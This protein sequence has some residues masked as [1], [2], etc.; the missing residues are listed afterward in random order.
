[1]H[2]PEKRTS[3]F[4]LMD[5]PMPSNL[6]AER[7]VLGSILLDDARMFDVAGALTEQDFSIQKHQRIFATMQQMQTAG[8]SIDQVTVAE[9]LHR[10]GLLESIDGAFYLVSLNDG[11]P[12]L[13]N[14]DSYIRIVREKSILRQTMHACHA[15]MAECAVGDGTTSDLLS[16]GERVLSELQGK[17]AIDTEFLTPGEIIMEAGGMEAYFRSRRIPGLQT[18]WP[19]FNQSTSGLQRGHLTIL[20]ARTG[21]GKSAFAANIAVSVARS[22]FGVALF[23][24]EMDRVEITDRVIALAGGTTHKALRGNDV[25]LVRTSANKAAGLPLFTSD[26][27]GRSVPSIHAAVRRLRAKQGVALVIVD[28]LQLLSPAGKFENRTQ[29]VSAMTRGLKLAAQDLRIP[30]LVLSQLKR[31][32]SGGGNRR[33]ELSD[34]RES[35]SIEQD[36]NEVFFLDWDRGEFAAGVAVPVTMII[37]K[38]RSGPLEDIPM[39]FHRER[40]LFTEAS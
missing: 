26:A 14:I 8:L 16:R 38:Q 10:K 39:Y 15:L 32:E 33:P 6:D 4:S 30:F 1:M 20:A 19:K 21:H 34:L 37:A 40:G 18:D 25:D 24:L 27:A 7:F 29:E 35:G 13:P 31:A 2:K 36:A 11:L 5:L 3:E 17:S 23:S 9:A 12:R 28:Y 22:G